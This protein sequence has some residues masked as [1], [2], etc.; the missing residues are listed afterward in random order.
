M[1]SWGI[2]MR[3]SDYG[4]DLLGTVAASQLKQVDF[5][6]FNTA[7]AIELLRQDILE[8]I[9]RAN[10][11][12]PPEKL[13]YYINANFPRDFAHAALL[14]AECLADYY[15][16]GELTV[17]EYIGKNCDP[18]DHHIKEVTVTKD[19]LQLLLGELR[20]AQDPKHEIYQ[21]WFKEE[22]RQAWLKHIQSV[23]RTLE[24]ASQRKPS[25]S[26]QLK[27]AVKRVSTWASCPIGRTPPTVG[28]LLPGLSCCAALRGN[29]SPP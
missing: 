28:T 2:T 15:R 26:N 13:G 3:E 27:N 24:E 29:A 5:S 8:E 16:T 11:G 23:Q 7:E 9:K 19:D 4:L 12:C 10:R 22:T 21:S 1:G 18:V 25:I 14:I 6:I 17:T 20:K